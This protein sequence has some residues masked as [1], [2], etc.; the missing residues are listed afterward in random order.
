MEG[1]ISILP[2]ALLC[3]LAFSP[4]GARSAEGISVDFSPLDW[5][6]AAMIANLAVFEKWL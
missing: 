5:E 3:A 2:V 4:G 1:K 6:I